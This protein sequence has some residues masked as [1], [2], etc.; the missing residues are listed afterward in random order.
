[1]AIVSYTKGVKPKDTI[2]MKTIHKVLVVFAFFTLIACKPASKNSPSEV[3]QAES[4]PVV[5]A[6][7][8]SVSSC[9]FSLG[10]DVWEPYQYVDVNGDVRG[11]D[12]ELISKAVRNMG[13]DVT[14]QQGTWVLLLDDLK[15][16]QVDI[17]LGASKTDAREQYA[18]FSDAYRKEEFS[19]YIRKDDEV[20]R[21]YKDITE[22]VDNDSRIGIVGDYYYGPQI[23]MLLEGSATSKHF[24]PGIMGEM[25]IG[26]LLDES[27][28]G[29]LEDSFVGASMLRRKALNNYIETHGYT[30]QTGDIFVMFSQQS[31]TSEQVSMLNSELAKMQK[32]GEFKQILDK[33]SR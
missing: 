12:I 1:M 13:C 19:L 15:Q 14:Y 16:G 11:L 23:S 30:I 7:Q 2:I 6:A 5:K 22:F 9:R 10:F 3:T 33:Y 32:N 21:A 24:V 27:I 25:N 20:R 4:E 31:V 17:L 28:E 26:R 18:Y 8:Q 29:F